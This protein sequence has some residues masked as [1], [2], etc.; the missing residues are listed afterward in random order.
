[1][2][3]R[4]LQQ[5]E[6][7]DSVDEVVRTFRARIAGDDRRDARALG[8]TRWGVDRSTDRL[9]ASDG[10]DGGKGGA[11][12]G[13]GP[14]GPRGRRGPRGLRGLRGLRGCCGR[15]SGHPGHSGHQGP[16]G[17]P[18]PNAVDSDKLDG[19]DS[20]AYAR[21]PSTLKRQVVT[22]VPS[23][24]PRCAFRSRGG[25]GSGEL[26][27][28]GHP[29]RVQE[30]VRRSSERRSGAGRR[31]YGVRE[32]GEQRRDGGYGGVRAERRH[33]PRLA[34]DAGLWRHGDLHRARKHPQRHWRAMRLSGHHDLASPG[35]RNRLDL[36]V[37]EAAR[38]VSS[39][40]G[41]AP[42]NSGGGE[43]RV[44][45]CVAAGARPDPQ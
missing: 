29:V 20:T 24:P 17:A 1:M 25:H 40:S 5:I 8:R 43:N 4:Y 14:R 12:A 6:G 33:L 37:Q 44:R 16:P 42:S 26:R 27:V 15:H 23:R 2:G 35:C 18:N 28:H 30:H 36:D 21:G 45:S 19:L 41:S 31:L 13:P 38:P 7:G 32:P 3:W 39:G 11:S 22:D 34:G 9:V 10:L